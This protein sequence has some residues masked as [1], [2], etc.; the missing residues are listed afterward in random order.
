M[1]VNSNNK[2]PE[3]GQKLTYTG[4]DIMGFEPSRPQVKFEK[5]TRPGIYQVVYSG[6][7]CEVKAKDC[8]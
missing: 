8:K 5:E 7:R 6:Y 2:K 1:P 4:S 3:P